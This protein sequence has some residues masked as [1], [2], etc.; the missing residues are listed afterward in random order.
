MKARAVSIVILLGSS[1]AGC[2]MFTGVDGYVNVAADAAQAPADARGT[3]GLAG[4]PTCS[5]CGSTASACRDGCAMA[6]SSCQADCG[7]QPCKSECSSKSGS[8]YDACK[9]SCRDCM[10]KS[11]STAACSGN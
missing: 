9:S 4:D 1:A 7:T 5:A 6:L 2:G 3:D 8:C 10:P 11:C